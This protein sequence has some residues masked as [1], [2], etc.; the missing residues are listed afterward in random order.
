MEKRICRKRRKWN[1]QSREEEEGLEDEGREERWME[2]RKERRRE[3]WG[4]G[5]KTRNMKDKVEERKKR[6]R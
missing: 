1:K 4:A 2:R 5:N 6:E 3:R